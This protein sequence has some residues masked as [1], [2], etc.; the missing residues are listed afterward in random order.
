MPATI[1]DNV[2]LLPHNGGYMV[3]A[4]LASRL[5]YANANCATQLR[6]YLA[7][8]NAEEV[9]P[10]VRK[11]LGGLDWL[12][13]PRAPVPLPV[14]RHFHPNTVT[15]FLTNR[16]N[17]RCTYCYARAG[18]FDACD[19]PAEIYRAALELIIRNAQRSGQPVTVT[20]HGGGEPTLAWESLVGAVEYAQEL[21]KSHKI[22]GLHLGL[23]TNGTVSRD[24]AEY[25]A[26]TFS[27]VTVSFDGPPDVQNRQRPHVN[28][29]GSFEQV[30]SFIE[31]LRSHS[32]RFGIRST[33]TEVN[34]RRLEEMV[35]FF[36]EE[37]GCQQV[38][39]EPVF[40]SGRCRELPSYE[41]FAKTYLRAMDRTRGRK[42]A[43]RFSGARLE[44]V[45]SSFGGCSRDPFNITPEGDVTACYEV[46][47]GQDPLSGSYF[48]GRFN[49]E[50]QRFEID[51]G[52]LA[53]L[54]TL[55]VQNKPLCTRC[56]AKWNCSG[57]CPV[58]SAQ[59]SPELQVETPRCR[60]IQ[61][62]NRALLE[63]TLQA[64]LQ[65]KHAA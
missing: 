30:M 40:L 20:F 39:L 51:F 57:D 56:F 59:P 60:M 50:R 17:L 46:C 21:V 31:V 48:F 38:H 25:I 61:A 6:S 49:R 24:R 44:G 15:L 9:S 52:K 42:V 12:A 53:K 35:D 28:G 2:F 65:G 55:T 14:D 64:T 13:S 54:R 22:R 43:L 41:E 11:Q 62:I 29:G 10:E 37:A 32:V 23:S 47:S 8:G 18:E 5:V 26:K 1:N 16:C 33:V 19:M 4:P 63:K 58:K 45:F 34:V 27:A 3:Y 7:T 36:A